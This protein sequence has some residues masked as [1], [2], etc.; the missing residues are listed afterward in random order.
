M[1]R[2]HLR[3]RIPV[4]PTTYYQTQDIYKILGM[5]SVYILCKPI[6]NNNATYLSREVESSPLLALDSWHWHTMDSLSGLSLFSSSLAALTSSFLAAM[7]RAGSFILLPCPYSRRTV[8]ALSL[9]CCNATANGVYPSYKTA[10]QKIIHK[11][12]CGPYK[13]VIKISLNFPTI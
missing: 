3:F 8:T 1:L 4:T 6:R 7:C 11:I 10:T 13:N 9:R 5:L 2:P 12:E